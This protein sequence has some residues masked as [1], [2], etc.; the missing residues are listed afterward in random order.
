MSCL[1]HCVIMEGIMFHSCVFPEMLRK[2]LLEP[3]K[4]DPGSSAIVPF[5]TEK[6]D[7]TLF[8]ERSIY[9]MACSKSRFILIPA[10]LLHT[11][12][13][14]KTW[15]IFSFSCVK[16][17]LKEDKRQKAL[18]EEDRSERKIPWQIRSCP[19]VWSGP[20]FM[21]DTILGEKSAEEQEK[22]FTIWT[23]ICF[24]IH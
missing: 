11:P 4:F 16:L 14:R 5:Q 18:I 20:D 2:S 23:G 3:K 8:W 6:N 7:G 21:G 24:L 10:G 15:F 1:A 13:T 9:A 12:L 22:Y 17:L 19:R